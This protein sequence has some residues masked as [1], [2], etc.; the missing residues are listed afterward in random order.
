[1]S[2]VNDTLDAI[3]AK[4]WWYEFI[5]S[6]AFLGAIVAFFTAA[7]GYVIPLFIVSAVF[8]FADSKLA[9]QESDLRSQR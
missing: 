4:R 1:M 8:G 9:N 3:K 5:I 2:E 7:W 6:A